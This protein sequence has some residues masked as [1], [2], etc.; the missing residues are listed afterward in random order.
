MWSS[1]P[2]PEGR[3]PTFTKSIWGEEGGKGSRIF[4]GS[5]ALPAG[6]APG[7]ES[8]RQ[9]GEGPR[10]ITSLQKVVMGA[11]RQ[12]GFT[13]PARRPHP[14]TTKEKLFTQLLTFQWSNIG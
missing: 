7:A 10:P 1:T 8:A 2:T 13:L 5:E 6:S 4:W 9:N 11:V 3:G 12:S 14:I